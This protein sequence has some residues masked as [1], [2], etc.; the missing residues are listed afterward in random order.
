ML[1]PAVFVR[2]M[3]TRNPGSFEQRAQPQ[4]DPQVEIGLAQTGDDAARPTSVLDLPCRR[5]RA[6]RLGL[7]IRSEVMARIEH[8]D[9]R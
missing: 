8:D 3:T 1:V 9:G 7:G 5:A 6:D 2:V 4:R